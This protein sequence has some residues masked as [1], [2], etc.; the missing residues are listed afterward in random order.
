MCA[1]YLSSTAA[2]AAQR[3]PL[4]RR[5]DM[6]IMRFPAVTRSATVLSWIILI[7][8][9]AALAF[10]LQAFPTRPARA[11]A[12]AD[13]IAALQTNDYATARRVF[14]ALTDKNDPAGEVWLAHLYQEG[15]GVAPDAQQAVTL[16][17]KAADAGS[18]E[19]AG[20]LG[21]VY[22]DGDGVLQDVGAARSWLTRAAQAGDAAAQR[23][24]GLLYANG[25]GAPKD[26]QKAYLW[27]DIAA[28]NGDP[29]ARLWRDRVLTTLTPDDAARAAAEAAATLRP[30]TA[31]ARNRG[32]AGTQDV[33]DT[34]PHAIAPIKHS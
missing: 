30:L 24:L 22:L 13:G 6:K 10:V 20:R 16:L 23:E 33:A 28:R 31:D 12:L 15:L 19:A 21:K 25:L 9:G 8:F 17:T 27:L 11:A 2:D 4:K 1:T 5:N 26:P 29:Q 14:Q 3:R 34:A 32:A 18:A 7:A